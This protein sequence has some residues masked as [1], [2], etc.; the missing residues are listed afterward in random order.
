MTKYDVVIVGAGISGL[1]AALELQNEG[2]NVKLIEA[3]DRPGGRVKTDELDG[4]LLDRGFQVLLTAYPEAFRLLDYKA[5]DMGYFLNGALIWKN[6]NLH[7]LT[8][9]FKHPTAAIQSLFSPLTNFADKIKIAALRNRLNRLSIEKIFTE[10]EKSTLAYLHEWKF[11]K[12]FMEAFF[13]PFFTGI[14]LE[15]NLQTSSRMFEFVFKMFSAGNAALPSGGIEAI[16]R[17]LA[18]RLKPGTLQ[19]NEPVSQITAGK[20][21]TQNGNTYA[22]RSIL[23]A[24]DAHSAHQLL[25]LPHSPPATNSVTCLYFTT[26]KPP[27]LRPLLALNGENEGVVNNICVPSLVNP[28]YA[29]P[30]QHLI[31]VTVVKPTPLDHEQ[32]LTAVKAE[33]RKWFKKEVRFWDHLKT[34]HIPDALPLKTKIEL[35]DKNNIQPVKP[36]IY[37]CGD[38]TYN[39]SLNG[40]MESGRYTAAALAWDLALS[41]SSGR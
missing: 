33:L 30:G 23:V 13:Q 25:A 22:C 34:Y 6:N 5:L 38:Y 16:P 24:T 15:P 29:P 26:D 20:V 36:G 35:P 31:S 14:F 21:T 39:G 11:S 40:A 3:T 28:N 2:L 10:P 27:I 1:T 32:L 17:Q 4:F 7:R 19:T 9:P 8:D 12:T 41:G 18:A 37:V